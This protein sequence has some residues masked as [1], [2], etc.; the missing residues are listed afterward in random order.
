[1]IILLLQKSEELMSNGLIV[2]VVNEV[3][4]V[5][6]SLSSLPN[7]PHEIGM[8]T[9]EPQSLFSI[10]GP[11]FSMTCAVS[12]GWSSVQHSLAVVSIST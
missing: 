11:R 6:L 4:I 7:N 1:V 5:F 2:A 8:S 9:H 10:D 3:G 12:L